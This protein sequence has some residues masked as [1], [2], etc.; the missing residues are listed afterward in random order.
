MSMQI[1]DR[2]TYIST[3]LDEAVTNGT[4]GGSVGWPLLLLVWSGELNSA[5][6]SRKA[7]LNLNKLEDE[8]QT[9]IDCGDDLAGASIWFIWVQ[10]QWTNDAQMELAF[11]QIW[12]FQ[13]YYYH[14]YG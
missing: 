10:L 2:T 14:S 8:A 13:E 12:S 11:Y 3:I 9:Q 6:Y 5:G 4:D 7:L 1:K